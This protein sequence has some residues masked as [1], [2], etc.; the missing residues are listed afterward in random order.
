MQAAGLA[1]RLE[2]ILKLQRTEAS[3]PEESVPG[4]SWGP[5]DSKVL[6]HIQLHAGRILV[7]HGFI[8]QLQRHTQAS[9]L[10]LEGTLHYLSMLVMK[11]YEERFYVIH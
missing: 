2:S 1:H 7:Y 10:E 5:G 3:E 11:M 8:E 9:I 6:H 4:Q